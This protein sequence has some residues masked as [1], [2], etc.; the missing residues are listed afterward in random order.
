MKSPVLP[1]A[2]VAVCAAVSAARAETP[3]APPLQ[4]S[5][6]LNPN[7]SLIANMAAFAGNDPSLGDRALVVREAEI[8]LQAPID[9]YS[10]ADAFI[11][12]G[13]DGAEIEEVYVTWLTLPGAFTLKAGK[14]RSSFGK[15]N[16]AH[17]PETPFADRPLAA[18]RFFGEEGLS[19]TGLATSYLPP[20]PFYLDLTAEVTTTWDE[21]PVFSEAPELE[22][23]ESGRRQDLGYLLRSSAYWDLSEKTNVAIGASW[24]HADPQGEPSPHALAADATLRWKDPRRA[25]YRSVIWQ[26]E[27]YLAHRAEGRDRND[28]GAFSYLECQFVRRWRMGIRADYAEK[29]TEKGGLVYLAFWPSEFSA[30]SAQVRGLRDAGGRDR[31]AAFLKLTFNIGP[32]GAHPF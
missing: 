9:P 2:L 11:A 17:P 18:D 4:A 23:S 8:G 16:R 21:A 31:L 13:D 20:L 12:I 28:W 24:A 15:F 14:F 19:A 32:H 10:R 3:L 27:T 1:A 22:E 5:N 25:I 30:L 29:P 6:I 26:T 7:L